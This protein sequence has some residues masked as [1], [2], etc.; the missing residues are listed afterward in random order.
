MDEIAYQ[1]PPRGFRKF[2]ILWS[3]QSV[4][5]VGSA[6]TLFATTIWLAQVVYARADQQPALAFA[7]AAVGLAYGMPMVVLAPIAG[8]WA[9]RHDR[10][11]TMLTAD[12][13]SG[14]ISLVMVVLLATHWLSLP[15][16]LLL[17]AMYSA[18]STWH[19]SAFDTSYAMLVHEAQLPRANG[20]MQTTQSLS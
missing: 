2:L 10:K 9:D 17:L 4:S 13:A 19:Y 18:A 1:P 5:V 11:R 3:T 16:L 15:A 20:M 12:T 7:L 14:I 6:L 8:A